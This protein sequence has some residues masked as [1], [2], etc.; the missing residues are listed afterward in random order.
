MVLTFRR[1]SESD[2]R[3]SRAPVEAVWS[4][5]RDDWLFARRGGRRIV[6]SSA[7]RTVGGYHGFGGLQHLAS[8]ANAVT[9]RH[10]V[11]AP[12]IGVGDVGSRERVADGQSILRVQLIVDA[13]RHNHAPLGDAKH[14]RI[15]V[16]DGERLGVND[17]SVDDGPVVDG[18]PL[19]VQ[20]EGGA[21][22]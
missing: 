4:T 19:D 9:L 21:A 11:E 20:G 22:A 12:D 6:S 16:D 10:E 2:G 15:G 1:M 17:G 3:H 14:L 7:A 8:D 5:L 13:R 18:M